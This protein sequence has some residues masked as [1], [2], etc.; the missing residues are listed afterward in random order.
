[1]HIYFLNGSRCPFV[2]DE[3]VKGLW[4]KEYLVLTAS[5]AVFTA[6]A[7]DAG[8]LSLLSPLWRP[9]TQ[10]AMA[11]LVLVLLSAFILLAELVCKRLGYR[12]VY[13]PVLSVSAS[14][15]GALV[16]LAML[17]PLESSPHLTW[18]LVLHSVGWN[19]LLWEA[20]L[21]LNFLFVAPV[22]RRERP[23]PADSIK[24]NSSETA[25][26][27]RLR[28]GSI[29][30]DAREITRAEA[31]GHYWMI[32]TAANRQMVN[33]KLSELTRALKPHGMAV[34]RSHWVSFGEFGPIRRDGRRFVMTTK[35]GCA[36]P[37]S[38][39]RRPEVTA[40]LSELEPKGAA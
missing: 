37:V 16:L 40:R 4:I 38:R 14:T 39:E 17:A 12:R 1:M 36:V 20:L 34:H 9:V 11:A 19:I 29:E 21:A 2:G 5:M 30:F 10:L 31:E 35:S 8:P 7:A 24:Q 18:G 33:V 22:V 6:E 27:S 15:V 32:H 13:A 28:I 3:L 23:D 25:T 26:Q